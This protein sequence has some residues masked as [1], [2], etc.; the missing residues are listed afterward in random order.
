MSRRYDRSQDRRIRKVEKKL[1]QQAFQEEVKYKDFFVNNAAPT[2]LGTLHLI[3]D[4][5]QGDT[6]I[7][8]EAAQVRMTS[9]LFRFTMSTTVGLLTPLYYRII[10]FWDTQVNGVNPTIAGNPLSAG[11]FPILDNTI[12]SDRVYSPRSHELNERFKVIHDKVYTI[13]AESAAFNTTPAIVVSQPTGKTIMK[14][15]KFNRIIQFTGLG[16][17][18]NTMTKN[19]LFVLVI[20]Q[21]TNASYDLATRFFFK[22]D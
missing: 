1:H 14:H 4:I 2:T 13:N 19:A 6:Q 11:T 22:D 8:R 16:V 7:T 21:N 20:T 12:I 17:G 5:S 10:V 18:I 15:F 9:M 3:N